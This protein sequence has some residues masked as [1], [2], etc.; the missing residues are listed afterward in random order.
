M[1]KLIRQYDKLNLPEL[2]EHH[3]VSVG[4]IDGRM[5]D[6]LREKAPAFAS[7]IEEGTE[8]L[9]WDDRLQHVESHRRD[10]FSDALFDR[11]LEDVPSILREP[12]YIAVKPE[13]GSMSFIR[14]ISQNVTVAVRVYPAGKISFRTMYSITQAQLSDYVKKNRAWKYSRS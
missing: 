2:K 12:D 10:F 11:C 5:M 6:F 13:N 4:R 1:D 7:H 9:F 14:T 3:V 8:I